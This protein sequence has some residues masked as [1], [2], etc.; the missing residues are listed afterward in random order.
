MEQAIDQLWFDNSS[1][2]RVIFHSCLFIGYNKFE[3][4]YTN[5]SNTESD[6]CIWQEHGTLGTTGLLW[7]ETESALYHTRVST[8]FAGTRKSSVGKASVYGAVYILVTIIR[9]L[10][11]F[12]IA[13]VTIIHSLCKCLPYWLWHYSDKVTILQ[14]GDHPEDAKLSFYRMVH[15]NPKTFKNK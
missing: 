2:W 7:S 3:T 8:S 5:L 1:L 10:C 6:Q 15:R 13:L 9:N 14:L 11:L 4:T 12:Y